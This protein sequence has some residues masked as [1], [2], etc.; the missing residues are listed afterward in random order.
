MLSTL[1]LITPTPLPRRYGSSLQH[2]PG[3]P[4]QGARGGGSGGGG[5]TA[6]ARA[7]ARPCTHSSRRLRRGPVL[8][9]LAQAAGWRRLRWQALLLLPNVFRLRSFSV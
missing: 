3:G 6:A 4:G 9:R 5:C 2:G 8:C 7:K 1:A